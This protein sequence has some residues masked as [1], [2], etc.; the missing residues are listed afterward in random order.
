MSRLKFFVPTWIVIVMTLSLLC[1]VAR[2][3]TGSSK[4]KKNRLSVELW[5]PIQAPQAGQLDWRLLYVRQP[6]RSGVVIRVTKRS[7]GSHFLTYDR[8]SGPARRWSR[9]MDTLGTVRKEDL[10]RLTSAADEFRL[11]IESPE[12]WMNEFTSEIWDAHILSPQKAFLRGTDWEK[13]ATTSPKKR[14][15]SLGSSGHTGLRGLV[16]EPPKKRK[17]SLASSE[18]T[19][20]KELAPAIVRSEPAHPKVPVS[21]PLSPKPHSTPILPESDR[22]EK[23]AAAHYAYLMKVLRDREHT[24]SVEHFSQSAK[25]YSQTLEGSNVNGRAHGAERGS[26]PRR[27]GEDRGPD[28]AVRASARASGLAAGARDSAVAEGDRRNAFDFAD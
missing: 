24:T 11:D 15:Q 12:E 3:G 22:S 20:L 2:A 17:Q 19:K 9:L 25:A 6:G 5:G 28:R 26:E 14:K 7:P 13:P 1:P 23:Y 8:S 16:P 21:T 27:L 18:Q 10:P 4:Y